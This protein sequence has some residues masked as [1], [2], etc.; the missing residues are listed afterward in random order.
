M[1]PVR[2]PAAAGSFYPGHPR[3]VRE[4]ARRLL[5]DGPPKEAALAVVVPHAGWMYSGKVAGEVYSRVEVP[6]GCILCGPNHFRQG[7]A[8]DALMARGR[9]QYPGGEVSIHT[10]LAQALLAATP[11]LRDDMAAHGKEHCLEVQIPFLHLLRP[12]VQIVPVLLWGQELSFCRE[13]GQALARVAREAMEPVLLVASTDLNHYEPQAV[14][15]RK[16]RMAIDAICALDP[17]GLHQTVR[18]H[19]ITMCGVA[20]TVAV[21]FAAAELGANT[22]TLVRYMTSGEV[23]G[24]M[25]A[26]VGYCGVII[27]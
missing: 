25:D 18:R 17:E 9:W 22:A 15:N 7:S 6:R 2:R 26:V 14:S 27:R 13:V 16:D 5:A 4:E 24:D 21:L 10:E 19:D 20:P 23:S 12:D 11:K 8:L 1:E 3:Q